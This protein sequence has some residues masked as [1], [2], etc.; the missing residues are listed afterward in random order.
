[1]AV[2]EN[3]LINGGFLDPKTVLTMPWD[4]ILPGEAPRSCLTTWHLQLCLW[5]FRWKH[6]ALLVGKTTYPTSWFTL[7]K[8]AI[9]I[10]NATKTKEYFCWQECSISTMLLVEGIWLA[11]FWL[12][13]VS[14]TVVCLLVAEKWEKKTTERR[15]WLLR[16]S[17]WKLLSSQYWTFWRDRAVLNVFW[18]DFKQNF[19]NTEN[20]NRI[21]GELVAP[22]IKCPNEP[23]KKNKTFCWYWL[24]DGYYNH[25]HILGSIIP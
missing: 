3:G 4:P 23:R 2:Y 25:P 14:S 24:N 16:K 22:K 10:D 21:I 6:H 9:Q 13:S 20:R 18:K 15:I 8:N 19:T 7:N 1:M 5:C 17:Y 11:D 12:V